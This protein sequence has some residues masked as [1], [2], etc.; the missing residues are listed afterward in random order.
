MTIFPQLLTSA[1]AIATF[2]LCLL[3][4]IGWGVGLRIAGVSLSR[5]K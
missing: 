5:N 2:T 3:A 1:N 4:G